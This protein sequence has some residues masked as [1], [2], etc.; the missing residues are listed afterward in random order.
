MATSIIGGVCINN[1]RF[2]DEV[3]SKVSFDDKGKCFRDKIK[4][5]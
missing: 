1:Y 3:C 5:F 4:S 2:D